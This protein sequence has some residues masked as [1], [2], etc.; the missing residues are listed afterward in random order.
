MAAGLF[1]LLYIMGILIPQIKT[2]E[3]PEGRICPITYP[4]RSDPGSDTCETAEAGTIRQA[5]REGVAGAIQSEVAP[6]LTDLLRR[7]Y[8]GQN[9]RFA[10]ES[11]LEI[12][13]ANPESE[14]GYYWVEGSD[15]TG[16]LVYCEMSDDLAV[17]CGNG[18]AGWM[19][20]AN[21]NMSTD[22]ECPGNEFEIVED[23]VRVCIRSSVSPLGGCDSTSF[24]LYGIDYGK[25]CGRVI[26]YQIGLGEA[27]RDGIRFNFNINLPY[28]DGVSLTYGSPRNHIWSFASYSSEFFTAC[29]CSSGSTETTPTFVG[30]NYFCE[31]GAKLFFS[32]FDSTTALFSDDALWDG[33]DCDQVPQ[34][35]EGPCCD[36]PP[37]F[38]RNLDSLTNDDIELRLCSDE[39]RIDE[40][41]SFEI[42]ELYVQ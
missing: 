21:V 13:E 4:V 7:K 5:V 20:V 39:Q 3:C 24:P 10:A 15:G 19:R 11:C 29:P 2:E 31:S 25:V 23:A 1:L 41:V 27:F 16:V 34:S 32:E 8:L 42:V 33:E 36:G 28:V 26:G 9:S 12:K 14:S 35:V 38:Y 30:E 40:N 37:W 17:L 18:T 6:R 22:P